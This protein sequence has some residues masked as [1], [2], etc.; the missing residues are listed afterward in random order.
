MVDE[1]RRVRRGASRGMILVVLR[2]RDRL[3]HG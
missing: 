1:K 3:S 2:A